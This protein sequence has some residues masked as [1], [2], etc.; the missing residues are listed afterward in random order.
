M[1]KPRAIICR[2]T[3]PS[4]TVNTT[5]GLNVSEIEEEKQRQKIRDSYFVNQLLLAPD[6][7]E[8]TAYEIQ[9][10][11]IL[12]IDC[13]HRMPRA[14]LGF[15]NRLWNV[16]WDPFQIRTVPGSSGK[17]QGRNW[18]LNLSLIWH[19]RRNSEVQATLQISSTW[20][21]Q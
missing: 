18:T 15:S 17:L 6:R 8:Q 3:D 10:R 12:F 16:D 5:G 14:E 11:Q 9:Q 13:F 7:P 2:R 20:E 1:I 19:G 21:I 4:G